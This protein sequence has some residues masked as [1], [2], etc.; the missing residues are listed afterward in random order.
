[1]TLNWMSSDRGAALP[2]GILHKTLDQPSVRKPFRL[3]SRLKCK[4]MLISTTFRNSFGATLPATNVDCISEAWN[5]FKCVCVQP[6][7]NWA[8]SGKGNFVG[9]TN[10]LLSVLNCVRNTEI[11]P[12]AS[13]DPSSRWPIA[14]SGWG[15]GCLYE[16]RLGKVHCCDQ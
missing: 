12:K 13:F 16:G 8:S 10:L 9:T 1:M 7:F 14:F 15:T 11:F 2:C 5:S 4:F 6:R 3:Y